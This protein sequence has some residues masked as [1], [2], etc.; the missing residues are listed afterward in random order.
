MNNMSLM[1]REQYNKR[2]LNLYE[3]VLGA[4]QELKKY[5]N[6]NSS[7]AKEDYR[8]ISKN[9]T[10]NYDKVKVYLLT[11][12]SLVNKPGLCTN[13]INKYMFNKKKFVDLLEIISSEEVEPY[14]SKN[15]ID[16]NDWYTMLSIFVIRTLYVLKS[17]LLIKNNVKVNKQSV[18]D[19]LYIDLNDEKYKD[20]YN[21]IENEKVILDI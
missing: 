16:A 10:I 5:K 15:D 6:N 11:S 14:K 17:D 2:I 19:N 12:K 7:I 3:I 13:L 18:I 4:H 21:I 20:L 9:K 8:L 1:A